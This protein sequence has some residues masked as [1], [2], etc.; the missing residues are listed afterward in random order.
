[1]QQDGPQVN[2]APPRL[3]ANTSE[4]LQ[5]LG[6]TPEEIASLLAAGAT[7]NC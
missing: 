3:G 7:E 1:M 5:G 4:I 2:E 6:Y